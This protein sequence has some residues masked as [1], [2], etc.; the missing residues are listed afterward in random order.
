MLNDCV[1]VHDLVDVL[2]S[3]MWSHNGYLQ[4]VRVEF[5]VDVCSVFLVCICA[6]KERNDRSLTVD[7]VLFRPSTHYNAMCVC[8]FV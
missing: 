4:D 1:L 6:K 2:W 5:C 8:V 3:S 7:F